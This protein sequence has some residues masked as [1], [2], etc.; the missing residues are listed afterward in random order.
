[1]E[2][3]TGSCLILIVLALWRIEELLKKMNKNEH[4]NE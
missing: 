1:M 4:T 3:L 2:I